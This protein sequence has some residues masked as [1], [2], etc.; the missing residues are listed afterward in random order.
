MRPA[1]VSDDVEPARA[2]PLD[3]PHGARSIVSHAVQRHDG[4][5]PHARGTAAPAFERD[6]RAGKRCPT[7]A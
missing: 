1:V 4:A 3:Q 7:D 2:E 5:P 6:T